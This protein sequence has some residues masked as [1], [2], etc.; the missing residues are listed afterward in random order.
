MSQK[1]KLINKASDTVAE[2]A[3]QLGLVA[4]TAATAISLA[5]VTDKPR[6]V[7]PRTIAFAPVL[8]DETNPLRRE[9]E[10]TAPHFI[11][12]AETQRTPSRSGKH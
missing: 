12:Y 9:R 2:I 10:E 3:D 8:S 6:A 1:Q 5:Q 11:S 4:M 7:V